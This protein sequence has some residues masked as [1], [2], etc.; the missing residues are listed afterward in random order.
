ME[1]SYV[2][3][4]PEP[5]CRLDTPPVEDLI[6]E[7]GVGNI[8]QDILIASKWAE[9]FVSCK[10]YMGRTELKD[11]LNSPTWHVDYFKSPDIE[12]FIMPV[13]LRL[14]SGPFGA[15]L[16][17]GTVPD[18]PDINDYEG[19]KRLARIPAYEIN[20]AVGKAIE[21]GTAQ[22]VHLD[23]FCVYDLGPSVI[24]SSPSLEVA[25]NRLVLQGVNY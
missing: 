18:L 21:D 16:I 6:S 15:Q 7:F 14:A 10:R 3:R 11:A 24:H 8:P 23:E 17:E 9:L 13:R 12:D 25:T 1:R 20:L 22:V 2:G 4:L 5:V 19:A